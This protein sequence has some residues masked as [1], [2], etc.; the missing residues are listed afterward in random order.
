MICDVT[1]SAFFSFLR[2]GI[3]GEWNGK[4]LDSSKIDWS[5][6]VQMA[7]MQTVAGII[8]QGLDRASESGFDIDFTK[9]PLLAAKV[10]IY[11]KEYY[12]NYSASKEIFEK[13]QSAGAQVLLLKGVVSSAL[14]TNPSL[15]ASGD[16]DLYVSCNNLNALLPSSSKKSAD[17]SYSFLYK[18]ITVEIHNEILDVSAPLSIKFAKRV[19]SMDEGL[20]KDFYY[21]PSPRLNIL[22]YN[23][24]VFKHVIGRGVGLRQLCDYALARACNNYDRALYLS[25]CKRLGLLKWTKI[26]D[27]FCVQYLGLDKD[28]LEYEFPQHDRKRDAFVQK[29]LDKILREGNFGQYAGKG[30]GA[31]NTFMAFCSNLNF[32]LRI[33]PRETIWHIAGLAV[34]RLKTSWQ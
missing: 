33:A 34:N 22:L 4:S 20:K 25:D 15:R 19:C 6:I 18:G 17:G 1:T 11:E 14:Y 16:I 31:F 23:S 27:A 21:C 28:C 5:V 10:D 3:W 29:L 24:H 12:K 7:D 26:L 30:S 32:S 9:I 13:F 2:A 8:W